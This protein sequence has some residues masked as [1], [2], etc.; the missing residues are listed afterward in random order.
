M[1][2][3]AQDDR[4]IKRH[5]IGSS[6]SVWQNGQNDRLVAAPTANHFR[7]LLIEPPLQR[8]AFVP[9]PFIDSFFEEIE[10]K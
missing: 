2:R 6:A 5:V 3:S 1:R 8:S 9:Q 7:Q 4:A 10:W